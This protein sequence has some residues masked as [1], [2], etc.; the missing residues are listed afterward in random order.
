[1]ELLYHLSLPLPPPFPILRPLLS[2]HRG[3]AFL[4]IHPSFPPSIALTKLLLTTNLPRSPSPLP[5]PRPRHHHQDAAGTPAGKSTRNFERDRVVMYSYI[6][7]PLMPPPPLSLLLLQPS[8]LYLPPFLGETYP[9][10]SSRLGGISRRRLHILILRRRWRGVRK[11][12]N[13]PTFLRRGMI[14]SCG[15]FEAAYIPFASF[16]VFTR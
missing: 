15:G 12:N 7:R 1:M 3:V 4:L 9:R 10:A 11:L 14:R 13:S 8:L 2:L 6:Y 16:V 5:R